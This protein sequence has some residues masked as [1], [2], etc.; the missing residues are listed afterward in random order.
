MSSESLHESAEVIGA[1]TDEVSGNTVVDVLVPY[2]DATVLADR[3][4]TG[5]VALVM[6]PLER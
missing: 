6:D 5:N 1:S 2:A 4:S 3:A